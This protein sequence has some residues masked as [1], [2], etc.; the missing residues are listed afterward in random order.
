MIENINLEVTTSCPFRCPQCYCAFETQKNLDI[1]IGKYWIREAA[2]NEC[3]YI[4]ISGGE[5]LLYPHLYE[6]ISFASSLKLKCAVSFSGFG[7]NEDVYAKLVRAGINNI[8]ISLNGST[9]IINGFTREGYIYSIK[10][11][12]LLKNKSQCSKSINWVMTKS[13]CD[14]FNN[15][16]KIAEKNNFDYIQVI[17]YKPENQNQ[18]KFLPTYSQMKMMVEL[19]RNYKGKVKIIVENC[20]S[21]LK[22]ML[23]D[24]GFWGNYNRGRL[25]GCIA[26]NGAISISVD[27]KLSPCR[28]IY[29]YEEASTI[30]EYLSNSTALKQ[31]RVALNDLKEPCI[32]CQYRYNCIHCLA[33]NYN[34]YDN[35]MF[36]DINCP[37]KE[38]KQK[39]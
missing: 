24:N 8:H 23:F 1:E 19:I 16:I 39:A 2:K 21:Q 11:I 12:E 10:A 6:L 3:K 28:H 4:S 26:G 17:G 38:I 31:I 22:A 30:E 18:I 20:Y 5:S 15:I 7:F 37:L 29:I 33:I 25:K 35:L 34:L 27:G 9:D 13:N 32:N 14:D 36:G